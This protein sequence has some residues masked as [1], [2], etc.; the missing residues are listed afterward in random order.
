MALWKFGHFKIETI[1]AKGLKLGQ[2]LGDDE[3]ITWLN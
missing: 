1:G 2:L 3:S